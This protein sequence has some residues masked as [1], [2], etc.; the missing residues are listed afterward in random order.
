MKKFVLAMLTM[1]AFAGLTIAA[2]A[3]I[4]KVDAE[5]KTITL[6]EEGK[7][8]KEYKWDDKTVVKMKF[9][10]EDKEIPAEKMTKA[11]KVGG[12]VDFEAKEG[13]ITSFK[14]VGGK[15]TDKKTDK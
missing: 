6:K 1:F 9:K 4:V 2:V 3:T 7:D 11:L 8:E 10:G 15:K 13:V 12:K 14:L 5:K